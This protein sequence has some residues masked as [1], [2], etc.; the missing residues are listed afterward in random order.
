MAIRA[1]GGFQLL[2]YEPGNP[3]FPV[4]PDGIAVGHEL[5]YQIGG[6]DLR[7]RK[8]I[9]SRH[10][11]ASAPGADVERFA[12]WHT[13]TTWVNPTIVDF[14]VIPSPVQR[15]VSLYNA[16]STPVTVTALALPAGVTLVSPS[17]PQTLDAYDGVTFTLEAATTGVNEFDQFVTFTTSAGDVVFRILGR[18]VFTINVIPQAPMNETLRFRTDLIRSTSGTEKAYGLQQSPSAIVD[19]KVKFQDDLER[20]RF[21]NRFIAG[22]SAL[23]VA[24]QKWYEARPSTADVGSGDTVIPVSTLNASF[25]AGQ[26][27]SVVTQDGNL[28]AAGQIDS[29]TASSITL[30][31]VLGIDA[32]AGSFV[33]PVGLGY[34]SGFPSYRTHPRNLEEAGYTLTFNQELDQS[35]LDAMFPT[36]TDLNSPAET[37]P[38][39]EFCN[40]ISGRSKASELRRG[41]DILDSGLSNRLAFSSL[42]Y[43]DHVSDFRISLTSPEQVWKWR[44]FFHYLRGSYGEF[45]VPTFTNDIPGVTTAVSNIFNA[46]DTDL[47]LLFGTTP[48]DRRNKI[49][50]EYPDGTIYY[51]TITDVVDN[52]ATEQITVDTILVVGNPEISYLQKSRILGD[53]VNFNHNRI[54]DVI[55]TFKFRTIL[56]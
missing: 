3:E 17:L 29:L 43:G 13:D 51:R 12:G 5:T 21:K 33:M 50:L 10:V 37:L 52:V 15:T 9:D 46:D 27:I 44:Q 53:T 31:A 48:V 38:I 7:A 24:G 20:I 49:R 41:E 4:L 23:V 34:V 16:R 55:L 11:F 6:G 30:G 47:S 1:T 26:P 56:T 32:P 28:V 39:L 42:P 19:Y 40:E 22:E 45:Y 25:A 36:L 35:N 18:R 8:R 2:R 54:D 14:G